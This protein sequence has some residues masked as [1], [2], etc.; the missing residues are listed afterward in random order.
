MSRQPAPKG[1]RRCRTDVHG[2]ISSDSRPGAALVLDLVCGCDDWYAVLDLA[3]RSGSTGRGD[4]LNGRSAG[5]NTSDVRWPDEG[6]GE[7]N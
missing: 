1:R 6:P 4:A 5:R 7:P 3:C 2:A